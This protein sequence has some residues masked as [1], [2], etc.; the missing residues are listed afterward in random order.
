MDQLDLFEVN[1]TVV[2]HVGNVVVVFHAEVGTCN[3]C[4]HVKEVEALE[5]NRRDFV[6]IALKVEAV[7]VFSLLV[8]L[9]PLVKLVV[10]ED[11]ILRLQAKLL[12]KL[13]TGLRTEDVVL[14]LVSHSR[15]E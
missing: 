13:V 8:N 3:D 6:I 11:L 2:V 12:T 5:T 1:N 10:G 9:D 14:S 15:L 4:F 7:E